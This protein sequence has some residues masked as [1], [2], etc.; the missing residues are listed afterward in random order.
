MMLLL[1]V[2]VVL[3]VVVIVVVVLVMVLV[4]VVVTSALSS[5]LSRV[6]ASSAASRAGSSHRSLGRHLVRANTAINNESQH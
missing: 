5:P 2:V 1:V 6:D 4:V 3:L